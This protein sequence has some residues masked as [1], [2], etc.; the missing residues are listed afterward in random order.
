MGGFTKFVYYPD[1]AAVHYVEAYSVR[2]ERA[3]PLYTKELK[4]LEETPDD[5]E[6]LYWAAMRY[7][8][9]AMTGCIKMQEVDGIIV[10]LFQRAISSNFGPAYFELAKQHFYMK[11]KD[12]AIETAREGLDSYSFCSKL[13]NWWTR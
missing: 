13:I 11:R 3:R 8:E 7:G 5:P 4:M 9:F 1:R 12:E 10:D 2:M 6:K